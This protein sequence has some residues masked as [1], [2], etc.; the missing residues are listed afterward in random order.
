[1]RFQRLDLNLLV[2]LDALLTEKSV[3]LAA[4]RICLSQ[5]ATSSA[6][7]RLREYFGD[8][9]LV[10]KGR[11]MVLTTRG[12]ELIQPVRDVLQQIRTTIAVAPEF[13]PLTSDRAVTIMASDYATEV[14][15][16]QAFKE[17]QTTAPHMKFQILGLSEDI[18]EEFRR[19]ASDLMITIDHACD[20]EHPSTNLFE[21]DFV[22]IGCKDNPHL[23]NGLDMAT[24]Q[25]LG[26]ITTSFGKQRIPSFEDWFVRQNLNNRRIEISAPSFL[27]VPHL[28]VGT[29]RIATVH[30]RLARRMVQQLPLVILEPPFSMPVISLAVQWHQSADTDK[31]LAWVVSQLKRIGAQKSSPPVQHRDVPQSASEDYS[32]AIQV[33]A[34]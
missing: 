21:D 15:L 18:V 24:Y 4:E 30:R 31:G 19:G 14:L 26:H 27:Q 20:P 33:A 16:S 8:D 6:L 3:S 32:A 1:M 25:R 11:K 13:D 28:L 2:A 29:E 5:S 12:E 34:Q 9:L 23:Q 17:F 22:V 7:G 10:M